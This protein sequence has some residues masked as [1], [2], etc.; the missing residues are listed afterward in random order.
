[1][2]YNPNPGGGGSATKATGAEIIT[3]TNDTHFA[4]PKAI[5]DAALAY[6]TGA[7]DLSIT[8]ATKGLVLTEG[9]NHHR[10][11]VNADKSLSV[12]DPI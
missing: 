3:G 8:D 4:T 5:A 7:S 11:T 1:M 2:S 12:S 10:V 6:K 9:T